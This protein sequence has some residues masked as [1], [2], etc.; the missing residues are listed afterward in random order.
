MTFDTAF[1]ANFTG[2]MF[3]SPLYLENGPGGKGV[4]FAVTTG[5][6]V[7]ALDETTG[8]VVWKHNI[9][10]S[11]TASGA[12]CGNISPIGILSTPVID[13]AARTIYVAGAIGTGAA[14]QRHEVHALSVDDGS[15][16]AGWPVDV[17]K[18]TAPGAAADG[19]ALP[20]MPSPQNQRSAL[21]LV[22]GIVYVA[23]GGHVGDCGPYHGWV[24]AI[25]TAEPSRARAPGPLA[26]RARGSGP[27]AAWPPTV[28][29]SSRAP[30]TTPPARPATST[31]RRSCASP[32]WGRSIA[33]PAP[34]SF[35]PDELVRDGPRRRRLRVE[36][37]D[38]RAGAGRDAVGLRGRVLQGR[39]HVHARQHQP[40]Q[41]GRATRRLPGLAGILDPDRADRLHLEPARARGAVDRGGVAVPARR[42]RHRPRRDVGGDPAGHAAPAPRALVRS[43][44]RQ[45]PARPR[46]SRPPPTA[47]ATR[48]SGS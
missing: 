42:R 46:R 18:A 28:T 5:N 23:Y 36:Q 25:N 38:V 31:A 29:A 43:A 30:A 33:P 14:I 2:A 26:A 35:L 21:S 44:R 7:F 3:A 9:G 39:P 6:D 34:T 16:R 1:Q 24:V 48:S 15:E 19:G 4:F 41:P 10:P 47:R 11:P 20:F 12:G 13:P 27:Q 8:A 32:A 45:L 22:N 17:S 37:P 40:G